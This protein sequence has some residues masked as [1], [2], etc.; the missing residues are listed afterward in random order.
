M[1][2]PNKTDE[3]EVDMTLEASRNANKDPD[4][5]WAESLREV[6]RQVIDNLP[7]HATLGELVDA[8]KQNTAMAPVLEIFTVH[9][10]IELAKKRP[11]PSKTGTNGKNGKPKRGEIHYDAEGNP[12]MDLEDGPKVI[13]RRA[14][15]P[16]GDARVLRCLLDRG[17]QR[18]SDLANLTGLTADQ[19]RIILR[20]LRT[21]GY[22]HIEGSG[23]KRR[24]KVTRH[25]STFLRLG[26]A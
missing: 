8:A 2:P 23:A 25:G 16:D 13:R 24:L 10:L 19:L 15:V 11:I 3:N 22:V 12:M 26:S 18:E 6:L 17:P 14:D 21:K 1:Q 20:H 7:D 5:A 9:E 4:S